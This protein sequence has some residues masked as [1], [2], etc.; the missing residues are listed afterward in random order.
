[1]LRNE[2]DHVD[3]HT[4]AYGN[5]FSALGVLM[6]DDSIIESASCSGFATK[7]GCFE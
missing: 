3:V 7:T 2:T 6:I 1:M 5:P 4:G